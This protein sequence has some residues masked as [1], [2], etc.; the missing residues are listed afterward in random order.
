MSCAFHSFIYSTNVDQ[1]IIMY[2][3]LFQGPQL[4]Q[5]TK[6]K[7]PFIC[8]TFPMVVLYLELLLSFANNILFKSCILQ[9]TIKVNFLTS[10]LQ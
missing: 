10:E 3:A 1:V 8:M 9:Y 7:I 4:K 6:P 2:Q 5:K